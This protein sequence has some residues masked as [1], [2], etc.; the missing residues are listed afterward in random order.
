MN[1]SPAGSL[2]SAQLLFLRAAATIFDFSLSA[3][4]AKELATKR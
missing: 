4:A 3:A 1:L 2:L